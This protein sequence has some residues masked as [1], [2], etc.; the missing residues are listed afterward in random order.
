MLPLT[1]SDLTQIS[2]ALPIRKTKFLQSFQVST[3]N[4]YCFHLSLNCLCL[5]NY[6]L[7]GPSFQK[8][9]PSLKQ[10]V[11]LFF[12]VPIS[13]LLQVIFYFNYFLY[14]CFLLWMN[15]NILERKNH[16][17]L[18]LYQ[19]TILCLPHSCHSIDNC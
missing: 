3:C 6:R 4:S 18:C 10:V 14:N 7:N 11:I 13:L 1:I 17:V 15:D 2:L 9:S 16:A 19:C 12:Y 8:K 5:D